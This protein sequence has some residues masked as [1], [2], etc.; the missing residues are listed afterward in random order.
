MN[1]SETIQNLYIIGNGFDLH[2]GIHSSYADF[3]E[4]LEYCHPMLYNEFVNIYGEQVKN[5]EWWADFENSLGKIDFV[6][7]YNLYHKE[8]P[9]E[10]WEEARKHA[11]NNLPVHPI[12]QP[13]GKRLRSLYFFLDAVMKQWIHTITM[14]I[15]YSNRIILPHENA[16]FITFN[17]TSTLEHIYKVPKNKILHIHGCL[18]DSDEL[19]YGHS[20]SSMLLEHQYSKIGQLRPDDNDVQ[21]VELAFYAKKKNPYEYMYKHP[22]IFNSLSNVQ[23]IYVYGLSFSEIDM[24]YLTRINSIAPNAKWIISYYGDKGKEKI[25]TALKNNVYWKNPPIKFVKLAD[26]VVEK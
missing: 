14:T 18:E 17:Y 5:G 19:I 6:R 4:W 1:S 25:I 8:I 2:H 23:N 12:W 21:E 3:R 9:K 10:V 16:F 7:F 24:P 22:V 15:M 13:A 11:V 26:L 20:E